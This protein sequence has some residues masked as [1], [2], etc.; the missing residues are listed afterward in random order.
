MWGL[1]ESWGAGSP[2]PAG[3]AEKGEGEWEGSRRKKRA[4][5]TRRAR[6]GL[7]ELS[8]NERCCDATAL[9]SMPHNEH[10]A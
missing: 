6:T 8:S 3:R 9:L 2:G 5:T 1:W 7:Q 4:R 10:R